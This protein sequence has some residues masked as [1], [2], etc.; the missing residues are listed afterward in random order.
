[1]TDEYCTCP[2]PEQLMG[3]ARDFGQG[4]GGW[5]ARCRKRPQS[6]KFRDEAIR[7]VMR[8]LRRRLQRLASD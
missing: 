2:G 6:A 3:T 7:R 5:C 1:M 8:I 4:G